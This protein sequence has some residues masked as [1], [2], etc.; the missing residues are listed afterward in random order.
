M[1]SIQCILPHSWDRL[2]SFFTIIPRIIHNL[3]DWI[4]FHLLGVIWP[5][6]STE[7]DRVIQTKIEPACIGLLRENYGHPVLDGF[8]Q[9]IGASRD[10]GTRF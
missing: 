7:V 8:H 1:C 2:S 3:A 5:Q 4:R 10:Q 9:G 6:K